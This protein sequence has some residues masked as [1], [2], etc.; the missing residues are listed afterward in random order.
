MLALANANPDAAAASR[1]FLQASYVAFG[2]AAWAWSS[3]Y[4]FTNAPVETMEDFVSGQV[5]AARSLGAP[6]GVDRFGFAWAPNNTLGLSGADFTAQTGA[7]LDRLAAAIHDSDSSPDNACSTFCTTSVAGAVPSADRVAADERGGVSRS[8]AKPGS[9]EERAARKT[10]AR[11]DKVLARL[12]E[13]E[14]EL[15]ADLAAHA[16]DPDRLTEISTAL[17]ELHEE[18]EAAELEWLEA[19]ELVE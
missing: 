9:A 3:S 13:R 14:A 17:G 2:N 10:V 8:T 1:A 15:S 19:A 4:G 18:K 11:L 12:A 16:S 6:S 7:V 5:D